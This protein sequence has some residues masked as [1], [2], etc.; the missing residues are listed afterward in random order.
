MSN[1]TFTQTTGVLGFMKSIGAINLDINKS[2]SGN[3]NWVAFKDEKG[4]TAILSSKVVNADG[5]NLIDKS[6]V[7]DLVISWLDG[8]NQETG[9]AV[10]GWC[11]HNKGT[12]ETVASFSLADMEETIGV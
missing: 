2:K 10:K 5:A 1:T 6:N 7:R 3:S 4:T 8:I 9:K 11:V 12:V